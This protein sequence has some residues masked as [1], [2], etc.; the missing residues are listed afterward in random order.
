MK[1]PYNEIFVIRQIYLFILTR[2]Y[3]DIESSNENAYLKIDTLVDT[4]VL[5]HKFFGALLRYHLTQ[6]II[7]APV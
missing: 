7:P 3:N 4:Y 6:G 5:N 2:N 1:K